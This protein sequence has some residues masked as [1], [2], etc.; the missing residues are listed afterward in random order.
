MH[1]VLVHLEEYLLSFPTITG[2]FDAAEPRE[3]NTRWFMELCEHGP[4]SIQMLLN[5]ARYILALSHVDEPSMQLKDV[6]LCRVGHFRGRTEGNLR[7]PS[8]AVDDFDT[9][10]GF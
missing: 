6:D 7:T 2:A 8:V 4:L 9:R 1:T 5:P 3:D 10:L